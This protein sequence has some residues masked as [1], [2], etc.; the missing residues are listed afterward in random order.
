MAH[1]NVRLACNWHFKQNLS[2][3]NNI[4]HFLRVHARSNLFVFGEISGHLFFKLNCCTVFAYAIFS[5]LIQNFQLKQ[6]L[7]D[8]KIY[9]HSF[10]SHVA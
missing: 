2:S 3:V 4:K 1:I 9:L 6:S 7:S 8:N 5:S 10:V